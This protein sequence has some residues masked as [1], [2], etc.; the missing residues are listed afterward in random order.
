MDGT[1][2]LLNSR[3]FRA[4]FSESSATVRSSIGRGLGL[5]GEMNPGIEV[6]FL[7]GRVGDVGEAGIANVIY[8][9]DAM[10][11]GIDVEVLSKSW[12]RFI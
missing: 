6:L 7:W 12:S 8:L 4:C 10:V 11:L 3:L 5:G 1:H 9:E 2:G